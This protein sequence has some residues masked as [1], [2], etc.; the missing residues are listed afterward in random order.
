MLTTNIFTPDSGSDTE[1][2]FEKH[3]PVFMTLLALFI[4]CH[5]LFDFN[6]NPSTI[7]GRIVAGLLV[8]AA[9]IFRK[10]WLIYVIAGIWVI[11]LFLK[12]GMI[13]T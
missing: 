4:A 10:K 11:T 9:G 1:E 5:F 6:E 13:S 12:A 7:V 2:Y 8:F 3:M